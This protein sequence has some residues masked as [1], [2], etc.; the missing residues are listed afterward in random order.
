MAVFVA[1]TVL[2]S[3]I[4][5]NRIGH[6]KNTIN[7][8]G[9][10]YYAWLPA[11][12]LYKGDYNWQFKDS[13]I[14]KLP[15]YQNRV[16]FF[17]YPNEQGKEVN[18]YSCGLAI[19]ALPFWSVA[20]AGTKIFYGNVNGFET[21]FQVAMWFNNLFW[22]LL[23]LLVFLNLLNTLGFSLKQQLAMAIM[24]VFGTNLFHFITFDNTLTH[25]AN[26]GL[27]LLFISAL[28][29]FT[30]QNQQKWLLIACCAGFA[31]FLLRPI[32][33]ILL[34]ILL[35][36]FLTGNSHFRLLQPKSLLTALLFV[37]LTLLVYTF[38]LHLQTGKWVYY[39]FGPERFNFT[40]THF[41]ELFIGY[42]C[43]LFLYTPA[44]LFF[45]WFLL[46]SNLKGFQK[47]G[48]VLFIAAVNYL[49]SAWIDHCF[50][51]RVGN[52]P[53]VDYF[54]VMLLPLLFVKPE[55]LVFRFRLLWLLP[56]FCLFYNQVLH[57]QYRHYLIDWCYMNK[58]KFW[59]SFLRLKR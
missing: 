12:F 5:E 52:R 44:A 14:S 15:A 46:K 56:L 45:F 41:W 18:K 25:P 59:S 10:G 22:L 19:V 36:P 57:Y 51:C 37:F 4:Q 55:K 53:M 1:V 47:I 8:D 54:S 26:L 50:G 43:G 39:S 20:Y 34:F 2:F 24:L 13:V 3:Y 35:F 6:F 49:F 48:L 31:V 17:T 33:I 23:G 58:D 27:C 30:I 40:K 16:Q 21:P 38:S 7:I 42:R 29:R 9:I 32:N 28:Y 11:T